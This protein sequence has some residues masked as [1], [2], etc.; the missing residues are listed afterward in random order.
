VSEYITPLFTFV[1]RSGSGKTT[2]LE[3]VIAELTR[4]GV[5]VGVVKH[6]GHSSGLDV[7]GK[8]SWR[9]AQAGAVATLVSGPAG[10][11][12][13]RKV[14]REPSVPELVELLGD[15][16][17]ALAEGFRAQADGCVEVVRR[18]RSAEPVCSAD[19]LVG[20]VTDL[21]PE[22]LPA[23]VARRVDAGEIARYGLGDAGAIA[24]WI[25]GR[26]RR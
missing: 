13:V 16:D 23:G 11:M 12:L 8:D 22:E 15:V 25:E 1:G 4:R 5:R 20:I 3:H 21:A 6:H 18:A 24:D 17:V 10:F 2:L 9:H 19:E 14:E 7:P 26:V